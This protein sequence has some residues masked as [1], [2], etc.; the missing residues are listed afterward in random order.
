[1][2]SRYT[3]LIAILL[4]FSIALFAGCEGATG[5]G[6]A[7]GN[8]GYDQTAVDSAL[9]KAGSNKPELQKALDSVS[10]AHKRGMAFLICNM[11]DADLT[12]VSSALLIEHVEYG[13][14]AKDEMSWGGGVSELYFFHYVLPYRAHPPEPAQKWRKIFY[15]EIAPRVQGMTI[16]EAAV[17]AN[18]WAS[19]KAVYDKARCPNP[20]DPGVLN[21]IRNGYGYC[22]EL[23]ELYVAAA[24]S[25]CIPARH[26]MV[27]KWAD[28][29][30]NHAWG[31]IHLSDGWHFIEACLKDTT[32]DTA[33]WTKHA[34]V[35]SPIYGE[36]FGKRENV[37]ALG[38]VL[39]VWADFC[40]IDVTSNYR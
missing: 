35:T 17:E 13:Y 23:T 30:D 16:E 40:F 38:T 12:S 3:I 36:T 21:T 8:G 4:S 15:D 39:K 31:E 26:T 20:R 28:K 32:L 6:G 25:I 27:E 10:D 7:G 11:K 14:K 9:A 22:G 5:T 34:A 1:M 29:A 2:K 24:R 18:Q 33:W 19:S 37:E